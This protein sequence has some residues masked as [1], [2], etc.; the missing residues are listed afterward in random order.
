MPNFPL[1]PERASSLAF[2]VDALYFFL[3]AL[4]I[5]FSAGIALG[6]VILA[7]RYRQQRQPKPV[8]VEGSLAL[9]LTWTIIPLGIT[10]IIFIWA[11]AIYFYGTRPPRGAMEVYVVARQWMWKF[12]HIEGQREINVL[13]VPVGRDVRMIMTSQD[14][15]HSFFVPAFRAK[16]DVL[17]GRY[18]SVWFRPTKP[19]TYHLFCAEYCG[20]QH[21]GMIGD[22]VVMDPAAYQEWTQSGSDGSLASAGEKAFQMY[23]CAMCHR[24]DTQGRG[25]NLVG[26]Y[27]KPVL[28][29]DGRTVSAD[30]TYIRES[31]MNPGAKI[32]SGFKNIMPT[33]EG[34]ISEEEMV[35]LVAYVKALG[36]GAANPPVPVANPDQAPYPVTPNKE[37][38]M[39]APNQ[40]KAPNQPS[41][42]R[43]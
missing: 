32:V 18:T 5:F 24:A 35:A 16:A 26:L 40:Q 10:M 17:P 3:V 12:E 23:G 41:P 43:K 30:E 39:V 36:A 14:V 1:F 13:H 27:G 2:H 6:I 4:T 25:P 19:G 20:T 42:S 11:A 21:S 7:F 8:Q 31:I 22:V 33:F 15:I 34:Q 38:S 28:L 29:D 37:P 9:E